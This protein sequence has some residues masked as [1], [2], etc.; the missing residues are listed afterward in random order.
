M[1]LN[2][3]KQPSCRSFTLDLLDHASGL[4]AIETTAEPID[5]V[6][7][8]DASLGYTCFDKLLESLFEVL[9]RYVDIVELRY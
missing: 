8:Q 4:V 2:L 5:V 3:V 6:K 1:I 9:K 7:D